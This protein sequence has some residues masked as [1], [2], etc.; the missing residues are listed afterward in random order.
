M[1][2]ISYRYRNHD[3]YINTGIVIMMIISYRYRNHDYII[4]VS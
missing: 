1:M 4:Q 3:D 2:I